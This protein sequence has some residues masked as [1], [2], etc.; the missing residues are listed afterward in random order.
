MKINIFTR[1]FK[2][3]YPAKLYDLFGAVRTTL[4]PISWREVNRR[5]LRVLASRSK[6]KKK[7]TK[8]KIQCLNEEDPPFRCDL[9]PCLFNIRHV[10][11][12]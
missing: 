5:V 2:D 1:S 7:K 12:T 3:Y 10:R 9:R 4:K 11:K 6:I 8:M